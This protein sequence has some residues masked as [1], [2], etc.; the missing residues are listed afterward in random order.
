MALP[1]PDGFQCDHCG[2]SYKREKAFMAHRCDQMERA[3]ILRTN[4]GMQAF[5]YYKKWLASKR[6]AKVNINT[7]GTSKYFNQFIK[8][9]KWLRKTKLHDVKGYMNFMIMKDF[10]PYM[11]TSYEVYQQYLEFVDKLWGP[12]EHINQTIKFLRKF[13]AQVIDDLD[14]KPENPIKFALEE[15]D[16]VHIAKLITNRHLSI[17][18]LLNSTVFRTKYSKA[19]PEKRKAIERSVDMEYWMAKM[20][21]DV[22]GNDW[23]KEVVERFDL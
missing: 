11:W 19:S 23:V 16:I 18:V 4:V 14:D 7:F 8:F 3:E 2:K 1:T 21:N 17:W 22:D 20:A 13:G 15:L 5:D 6:K 10:P 12:E 9:T